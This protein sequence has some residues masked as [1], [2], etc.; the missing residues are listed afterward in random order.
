MDITEQ[1]RR[2]KIHDAVMKKPKEIQAK[3]S[4]A[5]A[6]IILKEHYGVCNT[7]LTCE[8]ACLVHASA[9]QREQALKSV[10]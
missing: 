10:L 3:Y 9:D 4:T 7:K 2:D 1:K 6:K 5:L 8:Y